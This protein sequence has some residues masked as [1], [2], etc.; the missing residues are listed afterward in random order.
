[1]GDRIPAEIEAWL[2]PVVLFTRAKWLRVEEWSMPV[3]ESGMAL[4][5]HIRR[6]GK[7]TV[8]RPEQVEAI[9]GALVSAVPLSDQGTPLGTR[10]VPSEGAAANGNPCGYRTE[11]GKTRNG[12]SYVKV[13]GKR[14]DA[15]A[16]HLN[17]K[18]AGKEQG[19]LTSSSGEGVR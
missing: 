1:L 2:F 15:E 16:V 5:W 6:Q 17:Y 13:Y 14:E 7:N 9:A 3:F 11:T 18:A 19:P 8:L 12:R 10:E 4:A